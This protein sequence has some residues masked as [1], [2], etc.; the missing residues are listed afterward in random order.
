MKYNNCHIITS[1]QGLEHLMHNLQLG[2]LEFSPSHTVDEHRPKNFTL[3]DIHI[4]ESTISSNPTILERQTVGEAA[5]EERT[6]ISANSVAPNFSD[7]MWNEDLWS[8]VDFT[9]MHDPKHR[10]P[11]HHG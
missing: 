9:E 3:P 8:D 5:E 6:K 2:G 10:H 1:P 11:R 7:D 4:E